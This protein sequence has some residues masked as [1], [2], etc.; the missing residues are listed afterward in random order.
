MSVCESCGSHPRPT[1][2]AGLTRHYARILIPALRQV[3]FRHGYALT[4]H[5]SLRKDIDLVAVPWR[6][7]CTSLE[8][9]AEAIRTA[10]EAI[11][12]SIGVLAH[13]PAE[14]PYGR[15]A[16]AFYLGP[17]GNHTPYIDLSVIA[18]PRIE[19]EATQS[20]PE[21]APAVSGSRE[22]MEDGG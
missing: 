2:H 10:A 13:D 7:A 11:V 12:G 4:V 20:A 5:G 18:A 16:W 3:A 6:V 19:D 8:S 22:K 14:K 17:I 9:V 21:P 15:R 1:A